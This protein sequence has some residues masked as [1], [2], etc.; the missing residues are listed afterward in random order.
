MRNLLFLTNAPNK[1]GSLIKSTKT[2]F[3]IRIS[4]LFKFCYH[5]YAWKTG[6]N[7]VLHLNWPSWYFLMMSK[8]ASQSKSSPIFPTSK[9]SNKSTYSPI[10]LWNRYIS[11]ILR[12]RKYYYNN[13]TK[14]LIPLHNHSISS[15][16]L[17]L[18]TVLPK[19]LY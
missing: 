16:F 5:D 6:K 15:E 17:Y 7:A 2:I 8:S 13:D 18:C 14:C 19:W 9:T 11:W 3:F 4:F 1:D 12:K 10:I